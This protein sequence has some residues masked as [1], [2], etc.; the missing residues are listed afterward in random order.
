M[1]LVD[2]RPRSGPT[3]HPR[4]RPLKVLV[5]DG[6]PVVR[7]GLRALFGSV[8]G[9]ALVG[10]AT[11][12]ADVLREVQLHQPDVLVLDLELPGPDRIIKQVLLDLIII[13]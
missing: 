7:D 13:Q 10:E 2:L 9:I 12:A 1:T 5:A 3:R 8:E 11:S 4:P 6:Q